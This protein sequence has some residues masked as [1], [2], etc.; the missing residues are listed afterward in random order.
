MKLLKGTRLKLSEFFLKWYP[1]E[2]NRRADPHVRVIDF[3]LARDIGPAPALAVPDEDFLRRLEAPRGLSAL[4]VAKHPELLFRCTPCGTLR[5]CAPEVVAAGS[6][7]RPVYHG[8]IPKRDVWS[9]GILAFLMLSGRLPHKG[10]RLKELQAEMRRPVSLAGRRWDSVSAEGRMFIQWVCALD[11][12][13][14][15]T[16]AEAMNHAWFQRMVPLAP[17]CLRHCLCVAHCQAPTEPSTPKSN[18]S[19][20][21]W[22]EI[23]R[24]ARRLS[25]SLRPPPGDA[26]NPKDLVPERPVRRTRSR[27]PTKS[28]RMAHLPRRSVSQGS[29]ATD[30]PR[31]TRCTS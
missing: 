25:A 3:G 6:S 2:I 22:N 11:P 16:A 18:E 13:Q 26:P 21:V 7:D 29:A 5:Y 9:V 27:S 24:R 23:L 28:P 30:V 4:Q 1:S 10:N 17:T 12:F 19:P 31:C 8:N 20:S 15:P 14:R